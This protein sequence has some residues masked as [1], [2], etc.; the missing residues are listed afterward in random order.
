MKILTITSLIAAS[1]TL[2]SCMSSGGYDARYGRNGSPNTS[3]AHTGGVP[4]GKP[5]YMGWTTSPQAREAEKRSISR[6]MPY[7]VVKPTGTVVY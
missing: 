6:D 2:A 4:T 1:L 5:Q 7:A 3:F